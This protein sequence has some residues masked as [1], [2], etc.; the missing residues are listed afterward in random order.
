MSSLL[1]SSLRCSVTQNNVLLQPECC[2]ESH[3]YFT[4]RR[5]GTEL[6]KRIDV[7]GEETHD[8]K[9]QS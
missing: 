6:D 4:K 8:K 3:R 7:G 5:K 2:T 1:L 9:S